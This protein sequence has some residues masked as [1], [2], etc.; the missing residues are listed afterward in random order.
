[1]ELTGQILLQVS[2]EMAMEKIEAV[3][4]VEHA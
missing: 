1:L 2:L 3:G 4:I